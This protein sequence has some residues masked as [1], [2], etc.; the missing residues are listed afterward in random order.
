MEKQVQGFEE[1][2][3]HMKRRL[4]IEVEEKAGKVEE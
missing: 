3:A 4:Q 1:E 2:V